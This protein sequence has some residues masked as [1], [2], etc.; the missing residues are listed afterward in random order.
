MGD[1]T[2]NEPE[3]LPLLIS[4]SPDLSLA[5]CY[6]VLSLY[7]SSGGLK[8]PISMVRLNE[9]RKYGHAA[10]SIENGE[11]AL[12]CFGYYFRKTCDIFDGSTTVSTFS[13]DSTHKFGGLGLYK[14]QPTSVGCSSEKHQKAETLSAT[15]WTSLPDHPKRISGH[16]LV[17]LENQSLLL[18]GGYDFVNG[19]AR[20]SGIWR[21]KNE[22]WNKIGELLQANYHG[23]ALYI[24]RSIYYFGYWK[25]IQRLDFTE[26]EELQNV[27][28][29]GSQ[30][31]NFH[32]PVLFQTEFSKV[33]T[34]TEISIK[35][36]T[37][38][39]MS[40]LPSDVF[41]LVIPKF[42]DES[43]LLSGDG[44]SQISAKINAPD[45]DYTRSS[46]YALVNG[47]LHIFGGYYDGTKPHIFNSAFLEH[48]P[49]AA[50]RQ[51][52]SCNDQ[53]INNDCLAVC[54]A[55]YFNCSKNCENSDC[56]RKCAEEVIACENSCPCGADCPTGCVDCPEHPLCA[57]ECED[58]QLNNDDYK[59]CLNAAIYELDICLKTC[60][61]EIGCHN[62]CYENYTQMLFLCPCI[63]QQTTTTT[64]I[65]TTTTEISPIEP[66]DVFILVIP[67]PVDESYLQS[68]DGSSQISAT[69][70][71]PE[72]NYADNAAYALVNGK[73]HIFGGRYNGK[74]IARLDD[75][76]LNELTVR[77]NEE[78][79]SGLAA[80]SIE[81]GKKV[82]I[83][84]GNSGD[85]RKTC[86]IFDGS[87]TVSTFAADWT[88][89]EGGLGLY[90]N[91]PTSVGCF[92]AK[93]RKAE[94]LSATGWT[95]LP[96]HPK[97]ISM[98]SLV[99]L[100]NQSML[101]IGGVDWGN[102]AVQSG[103]WQLKDENWNQIG[104]LLQADYSGSAIYI[105][106]SVYYFGYEYPNAI[107]RLDLTEETEEL[108]NVEQIGNQPRN[109]YYPVLF[110]TVPNFC[111]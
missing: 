95:A 60:T 50:L 102:D 12:I 106:R 10:L 87:T 45:N 4:I 14:N 29:I 5:H 72:N 58:A 82:L 30:P 98:H 49:Q 109:F 33:T 13:A 71:A 68:G 36:T 47:K 104:E 92:D 81:N 32:F 39:K 79:R 63:E 80:L 3:K 69:I 111:T 67:N 101:H 107:E 19:N 85:I 17:G 57:D 40:L 110:Q 65:S 97:R 90:K 24:G 1:T 37:T 76:T 74:K 62:S 15:G 34:T 43:Y 89:R 25:A 35:T 108:Q 54:D 48:F 53:E 44:F 52:D 28:Q 18:I 2:D 56:F 27:A 21:L 73:L 105:G 6:K 20:Q 7:T 86:E 16:S 61:P 78:R 66:S 75:C 51:R 59:I 55:D 103:I 64:Q 84:F 83:C 70:N 93:H 22:N 42:V 41:I 11:K 99:A 100:E 77:L 8:R 96:Y 46:A 31:G 23:S 38:T 91:Q 88:H 26:T 94:T 9:E